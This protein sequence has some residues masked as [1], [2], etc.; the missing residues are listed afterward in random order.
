MYSAAGASVC[1]KCLGGT[2]WSA[3]AA[4]C[5][6]CSADTCSAA[7][8]KE[9]HGEHHPPVAISFGDQPLVASGQGRMELRFQIVGAL[10]GFKYRIVLQEVDAVDNLM[11]QQKEITF[12]LFDALCS[13]EITAE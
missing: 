1:I 12:S 8:R 13:S 10:I 7:G 3:A 4:A 11:I 2:Y 6:N 5:I 9:L